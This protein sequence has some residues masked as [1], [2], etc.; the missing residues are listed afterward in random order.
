MGIT[1][2]Q[3]RISIGY[4]NRSKY[5]I[6]GLK[7]GLSNVTVNALFFLVVIILILKL[8]GNVELNPGPQPACKCISICHVNIRSLSRS[9]LLAIQASLA[10]IYDIITISETHLHQG[11]GN[12]LF[13]LKGYHDIMRKDRG[14]K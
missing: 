9:K 2:S 13:E 14:A 4:F 12:D 5:V 11:V 7:I 10:N 6:A 8:S 3:Y 1:L